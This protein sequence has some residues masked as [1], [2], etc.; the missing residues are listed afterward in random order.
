MDQKFRYL[1][2]E[3]V[4]AIPGGI[5]PSIDFISSSV[6]LHIGEQIISD[7]KRYEIVIIKHH[8]VMKDESNPNQKGA[9]TQSKIILRKLQ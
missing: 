2:E 1:I 4:G 3:I 6:P 7:S 5:V 8:V 9:E